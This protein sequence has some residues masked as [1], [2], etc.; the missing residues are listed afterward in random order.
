MEFPLL[1][2][3]IMSLYS[4]SRA[5]NILEFV[6]RCGWAGCYH[7]RLRCG[8]WA[9]D[10]IGRARMTLFLTARNGDLDGIVLPHRPL[11]D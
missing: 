7:V 9:T 10:V 1:M 8:C 2:V 4:G 11:A 3:L 6:I 5:L